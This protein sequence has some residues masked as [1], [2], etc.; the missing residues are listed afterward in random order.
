MVFWTRNNFSW[1][2]H[3]SVNDEMSIRCYSIRT[4]R[5]NEGKI[6]RFLRKVRKNQGTF[7]IVWK[8]LCF[9]HKIREFL[10]LLNI[11]ENHTN[12]CTW[13]MALLIIQLNS[14]T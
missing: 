1:G 6:L 11:C 9:P 14:R 8:N 2:S 5:E 7:S 12:D 4:V 3:F 13:Y 10:L